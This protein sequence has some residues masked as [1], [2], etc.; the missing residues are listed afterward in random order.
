MASVRTCGI[1]LFAVATFIAE[2][3]TAAVEQ[4]LSQAS[5]LY[6]FEG[7]ERRA[8]HV[9]FVKKYNRARGQLRDGN[10]DG[11]IAALEDGFKGRINLYEA[12]MGSLALAVAYARKSDWPRAVYHVRHAMIEDL[13]Y[14]DKP[15]RGSALVL[16]VELETRDGSLA[17]AICAFRK[18]QTTDPAL[19]KSDGAAANMNARVEAVLKTPAPIVVDAQL[20]K[21]QL[22]DSPGVWRHQLLRSKFSFIEI[23]GEVKSFRLACFGTAHEAPVDAETIWDVPAKAGPCI[24]RVDGAP[25]AS[26]KLIESW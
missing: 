1:I 18:L 5:V 11:A 26:F 7:S 24:L 4:A 3:A 15:L 22:F 19:A 9:E 6:L 14:L 8:D 17:R 16:L 25:G 2:H 23:K 13:N 12:A 21:H 10:V 20:T